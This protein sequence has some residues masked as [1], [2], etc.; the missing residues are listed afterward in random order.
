ML[1]Y[2]YLAKRNFRK[3]RQNEELWFYIAV[4]FTAGTIATIILLPH[5]KT[6]EAAFRNGFF[7][8]ISIM[9]CTGFASDDYLFWPSAGTMLIFIMMFAGG[10]T[11]STSGGIKMSRHLMV[12]KNIRRVVIRLNHPK[13]MAPLKLN[14]KIVSDST[15]NSIISFVILYIFLFIIGTI[16]VVL[17]GSDPVTSASSVATCMAG[18]GPGLG[19]VGPM[20]NYS[21]LPEISKIVLSLLMIIGRLEI[22]TVFVLFTKS[23]WRL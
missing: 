12:L 20:S 4:A 19:S 15:N 18:I 5:S 16:I 1:V 21:A 11:G 13:A 7:Q 8:I 22:I 17:A 9:T 14:G 3:I 2:Y 10:S 6:F 23:F